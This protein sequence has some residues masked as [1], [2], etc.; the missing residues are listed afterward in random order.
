MAR[1]EVAQSP[2]ELPLPAG[3]GAIRPAP[4]NQNERQLRVA[5]IVGM[6][7][8]LSISAATFVIIWLS[9]RLGDDTDGDDTVL[10]ET[11][12]CCPGEAAKLFAVFDNQVAPCKDFFA[13]VCRNATDKDLTQQ[14]A[15]QDILWNIDAHIITGTSNYGV[16]AAATLQ[17]F[18]R[19]CVK[20]IWQRDL[21]LRDTLTAVFDIANISKRM[22][23]A[24]LLRFA[25]EVQTR[26]NLFFYFYV[27]FHEGVTYFI[28]NLPRLSA[29]EHVCDDACNATVLSSVNAYLDANCTNE[30][31]AAW[32]N[33]F[34]EHDSPRDETAWG[35]VA[36]AFGGMEAELFRAILLE[37]FIDVDVNKFAIVYPKAELFADVARLWN[38]ANQPLSLCHAL[39]MVA[40][41]ALDGIVKDDPEVNSPTLRTGE[42]CQ[43]HLSGSVQLLRATYVTA[44]TS[45]DKDRQLRAI[46]EATRRS[47][48]GYEPLRELVATG[49]D[50]AN[51][52]N[53]MRSMT[54]MLPGDLV[55]PEM[56]VPVLNNSGFVRNVFR[57]TSLEYDTTFEKLRRGLPVL[58][59]ASLEYTPERMLFVNPRTLYVTAPAY[60][61]LSAGTANP[62]LADAPVIASRMASSMWSNV[63]QWNGWSAKTRIALQSFQECVQQSERLSVYDVEEDPFTLTMGLRIA[64]IVAAA[65][66]AGGD[67][68]RTEWFRTKL[69]WSL[70]RMSEAQ[71]FYARYAYFR[72]SGEGSRG[73]VNGAIRHSTDFSIAFQ[74]QPMSNV[75]NESGCSDFATTRAAF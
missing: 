63:R 68:A 18:Y 74:C 32:E 45:P 5:V 47:F 52:E 70:D 34:S 30:Q 73:L 20:E 21:R 57:L 29:F 49:N 16:K 17:A 44:L 61:W 3:S 36:M 14:N 64:A 9:V 42:V 4:G 71:F 10:P 53:L 7:C 41:S 31:I 75:G 72:C 48:I 28:R 6:S 67:P 51:F 1:A 23:H 19:S 26:Y 24:Q 25:L 62:L 11:A 66:Y 50:T 39:M 35:E 12:F 40:L 33:L 65:S 46:F 38:V 59:D 58:S 27:Y 2:L 15:P 60:A 13:Y 54:L 8:A 37:F 43:F 69:A 56:N 22:T 55:L